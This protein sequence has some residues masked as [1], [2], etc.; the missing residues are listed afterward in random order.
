MKDEILS[1]I[2]NILAVFRELLIYSNSNYLV[3]L[4]D[5]QRLC[6]FKK[7]VI[8]NIADINSECIGNLQEILTTSTH[9]LN[10]HKRA[11]YDI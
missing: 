3:L 5:I 9:N 2:D 4:T 10:M 8:K 6:D 1:L 7:A 11:H